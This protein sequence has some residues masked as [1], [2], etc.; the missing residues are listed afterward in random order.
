[1]PCNY[2]LTAIVDFQGERRFIFEAQRVPVITQR[3]SI[4]SR[5]TADEGRRNG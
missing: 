3:A 4:A 2:A 1:M 5:L